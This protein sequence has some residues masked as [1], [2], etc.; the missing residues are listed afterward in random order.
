MYV[1]NTILY[2]N[3]RERS[4]PF[5]NPTP[6]KASPMSSEKEQTEEKEEEEKRRL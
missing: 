3:W 2:I 6:V 1:I 5:L 4:S